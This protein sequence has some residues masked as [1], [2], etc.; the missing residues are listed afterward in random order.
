[1]GELGAL[2]FE[3]IFGQAKRVKRTTKRTE[4]H[5]GDKQRVKIQQTHTHRKKT[6]KNHW[7]T[8]EIFTIR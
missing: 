4:R 7:T 5:I 2:W 3:G 6:E 8:N 1:M